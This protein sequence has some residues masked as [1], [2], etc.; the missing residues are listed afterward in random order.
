MGWSFGFENRDLWTRAIA[1]T[2]A[3]MLR[4]SD[5][6][7]TFCRLEPTEEGGVGSMTF[8]RSPPLTASL[9][10]SLQYRTSILGTGPSELVKLW[11]IH[12]LSMPC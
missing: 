7:H 8:Q 9:S 2:G 1:E 6:G 5:W 12:T 10:L 11:C 3:V 4:L